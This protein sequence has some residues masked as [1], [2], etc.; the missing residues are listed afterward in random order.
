M[1]NGACWIQCNDTVSELAAAFR[2]NGWG[3][4]LAPLYTAADQA[5]AQLASEASW[6]GYTQPLF[7]RNPDDKWSWNGDGNPATY[8]NW[9]PGQP[10]DGDD[11]EN[12]AENCAYMSTPTGLWQD[13]SCF[14]RFKF[15]CR[16]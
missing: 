1:C 4:K 10:N 11:R 3:G 13:T 8:T 15:A 14:A 12:S 5:C 9:A 6:T 16:R 7:Q 2:C